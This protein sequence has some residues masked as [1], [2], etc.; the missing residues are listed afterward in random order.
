ME[1]ILS[2]VAKGYAQDVFE[3]NLCWRASGI[4]NRNDATEILKKV[5]PNGY[6]DFDP[7]NL[8]HLPRSSVVT[9]AR[10][11]SVCLYV[12]G[13]LERDSRLFA[14]EWDYNPETNETRIWW[15]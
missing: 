2:E 14:Q 8:I 5:L 4:V 11:Y 9:I 10:E 13:N 12:A 15:D 3:R 7:E 6:N 1:T